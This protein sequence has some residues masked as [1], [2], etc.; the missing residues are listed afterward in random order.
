MYTTYILLLTWPEMFIVNRLVI[1]YIFW[2]ENYNEINEKNKIIHRQMNRCECIIM[3]IVHL[4]TASF[5]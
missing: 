1:G 3:A 2:I 4:H 5:L